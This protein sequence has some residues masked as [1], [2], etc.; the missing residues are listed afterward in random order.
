LNITQYNHPEHGVGTSLNL[1]QVMVKELIEYIAKDANPDDD[2]DFDFDEDDLDSDNLE[3][4]AEEGAKP[5]VPQ[6]EESDDD[7]ED[8]LL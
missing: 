1:G 5:D 2:D 3:E 4:F 6:V 7:D 8:G